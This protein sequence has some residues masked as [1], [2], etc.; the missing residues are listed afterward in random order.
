[1]IYGQSSFP[2]SE[3]VIYGQTCGLH[4]TIAEILK[5]LTLPILVQ[6]HVGDDSVVLAV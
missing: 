4:H 1:M 5:L 6:G 3:A 2:R